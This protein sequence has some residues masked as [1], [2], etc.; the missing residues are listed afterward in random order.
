MS[1][2]DSATGGTNQVW[3]GAVLS[4]SGTCFYINDQATGTGAGTFY[5]SGP[6]DATCTGTTAL[7]GATAGSF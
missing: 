4:K 7:T 2:T 6:G 3:S 1:V 5:G